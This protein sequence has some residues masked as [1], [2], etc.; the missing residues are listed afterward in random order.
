MGG[1]WTAF[2]FGGGGGLA[3]K[4]V[5]FKK[6]VPSHWSEILTRNRLFRIKEHH[7]MV[8]SEFLLRWMT[9]TTDSFILSR[10]VG[11]ICLFLGQTL[12]KIL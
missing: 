8:V 1:S 12:T 5:C 6:Y 11:K 4:R 2:R 9:M 10:W 7:L 3:R